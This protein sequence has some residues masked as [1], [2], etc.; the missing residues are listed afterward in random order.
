VVIDGAEYYGAG[1]VSSLDVGQESSG[2]SPKISHPVGVDTRIT[3]KLIAYADALEPIGSYSHLYI[4]FYVN[5]ET[6][7]DPEGYDAF[8]FRIALDNP[9]DYAIAALLE[10]RVEQT[11]NK[12]TLYVNDTK[13]VEAQL[14]GP[15]ASFKLLIRNARYQLTSESASSDAHG[16]VIY[17]VVAEYYDRW[18]D[19]FNTM[20]QVMLITMFITL[21]VTLFTSVLR[22][23]RRGAGE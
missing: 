10:F 1:L 12:I 13:I 14:T 6:A 23:V 4:V 2:F 8:G 5:S 21:G 20:T 22:A 18:E 7:K 19:L 3:I 15:L 9:N 11:S 16:I 17:E